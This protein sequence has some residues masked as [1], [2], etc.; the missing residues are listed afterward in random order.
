MKIS[1]FS[2]SD[3]YPDVQPSAHRFVMEQ[4][5]LA[6]AAEELGYYGYFNAEH[7]FHEYGL[8][9]DPAVLFSA[10]AVKTKKLYF[11]P[12]VS[13]LTFHHPLRVAEQ[14]ALVDQMSNGRLILGVGSGYL[15]HEF[16]G[17]SMSPA[18]KRE[19]FDEILTIMEKALTGERFSYDG[20]FFN[21]KNVK[22]NL[23][24]YENRKIPTAI[25][26]LSE[27]GSYY[28]AKKGYD[29]MTIPYATAEKLDDLVPMYQNFRKGWKESGKAGNGEVMAAVH[30]H[31]GN[32]NAQKD[33][34]GRKHLEKYIYSR[35]YAR[36]SSY[37]ECL[38]RGV[39]AMGNPDDVRGSLQNL[40]NTGIDH[41]MMMFN[42]GAMPFDEVLKSMEITIKEVVPQLKPAPA[43]RLTY[44][45]K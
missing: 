27:L 26:I 4:V 8:I 20:Q 21:F 31:T 39:V 38:N 30:V 33:T 43:E 37:D 24:G 34:L 40:I 5:E 9:T 16:E 12:A 13:L 10:I 14:W 15:M 25:A 45:G 22:L 11:G 32:E 23:I 36:H 42:F 6:Q 1:L 18:N 29:V 2:V 28:V 17:F 35:L 19:K 41:L 44:S 7:H 3:Y